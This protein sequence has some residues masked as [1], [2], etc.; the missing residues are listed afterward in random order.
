[1]GQG[2]PRQAHRGKNYTDHIAEMGESEPLRDPVVFLKPNTC[3]IGP[4]APIV[5][6]SWSQ[7]VHYEAELAVVIKTLAKDIPADHADDVILGYTINWANCCASV[8]IMTR[9]ATRCIDW[10]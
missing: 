6:P 1:M 7:E 9:S 4:D 10:R 3:V 5:L 2:F 8:R